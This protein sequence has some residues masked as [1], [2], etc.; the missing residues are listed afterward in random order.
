[1]GLCAP[2]PHQ[3][4]PPL[5]PVHN[6]TRFKKSTGFC[7]ELGDDVG[8]CAPHPA[9]GSSSLDPVHN[10]TGFRKST[11]CCVRQQERMCC[12]VPRQR[13]SGAQA[14]VNLLTG[15]FRMIDIGKACFPECD[16]FRKPLPAAGNMAITHVT[17]CFTRKHF[18][19]PANF[20]RGMGVQGN[21][22]PASGFGGEEPP[23]TS[24]PAVRLNR[25]NW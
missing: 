12:V 2:H 19:Q 8:L 1:M 6:F 9:P 20:H 25:R 13:L 10:F 17:Q 23:K 4:V 11:G 24:L 21:H 22:S 15:G 5:D 7:V 3:G 14:P 16:S 18:A